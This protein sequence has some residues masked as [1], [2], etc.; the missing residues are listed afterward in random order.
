[1]ENVRS[2]N[3]IKNSSFKYHD[4]ETKKL[5]YYKPD[6]IEKNNI[7]IKT[8]KT[9]IKKIKNNSIKDLIYSNKKVPLNWRNQ[10][11]YQDQVMHIF[12]KD[13]NFL[14]YIGNM[15]GDNDKGQ[16]ILNKKLFTRNNEF[17]KEKYD[18]IKIKAKN[19]IKLFRNKSMD[20]REIDIYLNKLKKNFPIK[21][22]LKDLFNEKT[23][24]SVCNRNQ[25]IDINKNIKERKSYLFTTEKMKN[26]INKNIYI[27]LIPKKG[28]KKNLNRT[29]SAIALNRGKGFIDVDNNNKKKKY[30]I[31]D[32]YA[33]NQLESI[34]FFGPYYSYCSECGKRNVDFYKN[35]DS[36][37][38]IE[39]VGQIKKNKDEQILRNLNRKKLE[40]ENK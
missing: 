2:L 25:I 23:L 33:M 6:E 1:M 28:N 30:K 27:N 21:E 18:F 10:T 24:N 35:I 4:S 13:Q 12:T 9:K 32:I 17:K 39:I 29:K 3:L 7:K 5:F 11:S 15:K 37:I 19:K 38:L 14:K 40:K 20:M 31:D 8:Y 34:N 26:N 22:K 16:L 36:D